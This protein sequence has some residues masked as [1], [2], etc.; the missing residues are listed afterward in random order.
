MKATAGGWKP[1]RIDG[2]NVLLCIPDQNK[3]GGQEMR[4]YA[5]YCLATPKGRMIA[6]KAD[7]TGKVPLWCPLGDGVLHD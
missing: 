6:G 5:Y 2:K 1:E 3:H 7:Y 4:Q